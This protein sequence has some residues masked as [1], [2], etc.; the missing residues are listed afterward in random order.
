MKLLKIYSL[1]NSK[2]TRGDLHLLCA[3]N[4]HHHIGIWQWSKETMLHAVMGFFPGKFW[5]QNSIIRE[6]FKKS[7]TIVEII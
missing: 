3:S 2:Q 5:S 6:N 1:W 4:T 7:V